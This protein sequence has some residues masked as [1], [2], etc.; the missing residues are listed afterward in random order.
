MISAAPARAAAAPV[1]WIRDALSNSVALLDFEGAAAELV[2]TFKFRGAHHGAP[3]IAEYPVEP[4]GQLLPIQYTPDE[5][6]DLAAFMRPHSD[7]L[8]GAVAAWARD[9]LRA[10]S[11]NTAQP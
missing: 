1:R 2:V 9:F 7:D 4:R 6:T 5:W 3:S 11:S 8:D 10:S